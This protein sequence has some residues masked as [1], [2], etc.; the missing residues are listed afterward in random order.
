METK[1]TKQHLITVIEALTELID[2]W[3]DLS[4]DE[5]RGRSNDA[6]CL[7]IWDDGSGKLGTQFG[8]VFNQQI[9]FNTPEE[10]YQALKPWLNFEEETGDTPRRARQ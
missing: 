6:L 9:E 7:L 2:E 5:D 8:D 10:L 1:I 4:M 3:N